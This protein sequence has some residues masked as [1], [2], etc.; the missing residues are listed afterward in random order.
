MSK[1]IKSNKLVLVLIL[2][3]CLS[4]VFMSGCTT[5]EE[6]AALEVESKYNSFIEKGDKYLEAKEYTKAEKSYK[7]AFDIESN[8]EVYYKLLNLYVKDVNTVKAQ[9]LIEEIKA[10]VENPSEELSTLMSQEEGKKWYPIKVWVYDAYHKDEFNFD[11]K[12]DS[13]GRYT[14]NPLGDVDGIGMWDGNKYVY[15]YYADNHFKISEYNKNGRLLESYE[16]KLDDKDRVIW[17]QRINSQGDR[18]DPE[19][20]TY[21]D[22]KKKEVKTGYVVV[23][24]DYS[25]DRNEKL[26]DKNGNLL[27]NDIIKGGRSEAVYTGNDHLGNPTVGTTYSDEYVLQSL[28]YTYVYC[29]KSDLGG[30]LSGFPKS[31]LDI[32]I[33]EAQEL[34]DA[35]VDKAYEK[36]MNCHYSYYDEEYGFMFGVDDGTLDPDN[37]SYDEDLFGVSFK[38]K[39]FDYYND[40]YVN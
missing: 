5:K 27:S 1:V 24:D 29:K 36:D 39:I 32:S 26:Y 14:Y 20:F 21:D 34:L 8:S 19:E 33:K 35:Y 2:M 6:K 7:K 25:S 31:S 40:S 13:N 30:D 4:A 23:E 12:Y 16:Y 10:N 15:D 22:S 11:Y 28:K 37:P 18:S 9:E 17:Q 3:L 38:G